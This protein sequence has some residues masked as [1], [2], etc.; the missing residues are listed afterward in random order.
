LIE[1]NPKL[2]FVKWLVTKVN[3]NNPDQMRTARTTIAGV[4]VVFE[5][6]IAQLLVWA[7]LAYKGGGSL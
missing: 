3:R 7:S 5:I 6:V 4:M 1:T 2:R